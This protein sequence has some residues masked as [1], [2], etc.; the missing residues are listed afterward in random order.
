MRMSEGARAIHRS[1][2][3][4]ERRALLPA[5]GVQHG[6]K[7][8][9]QGFVRKSIECRRQALLRQLQVAAQQGRLRRKPKT[10]RGR[11]AFANPGLRGLFGAREISAIEINEFDVCG[12]S[13][14]IR[15]LGELVGDPRLFKPADMQDRKSVV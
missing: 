11:A 10:I 12:V 13:L 7:A 2:N 5:P 15:S 9:N 4:F 1:A 8:D 14:W 3:T 6:L